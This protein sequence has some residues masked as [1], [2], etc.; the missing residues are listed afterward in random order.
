MNCSA[1]FLK[2]D[3]HSRS[4]RHEKPRW[5]NLKWD[6][7][8]GEWKKHDFHI[9]SPQKKNVLSKLEPF[10][11]ISLN[12]LFS[13]FLVSDLGTGNDCKLWLHKSHI[14]CQ[15]LALSKLSQEYARS[16]FETWPKLHHASPNARFTHLKSS[17]KYIYHARPCIYRIRLQAALPPWYTMS[18]R[19]RSIN[20]CLIKIIYNHHQHMNEKHMIFMIWLVNSWIATS[21]NDWLLTVH[22]DITFQTP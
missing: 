18:Q 6:K 15:A 8:H 4:W 2:P 10:M 9:L 16:Q 20:S 12:N 21:F 13:H 5:E 11:R 19:T 17:G 22:L 3:S 7:K 14:Q 1:R